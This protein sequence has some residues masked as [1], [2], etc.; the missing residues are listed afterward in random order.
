MSQKSKNFETEIP[1]V[2]REAYLITACGNGDMQI[3]REILKSGSGIMKNLKAGLVVKA[4]RKNNVELLDL[5]LDQGLDNQSE[6][7]AQRYSY[8]INLAISQGNYA[9]TKVLLKPR[10]NP[11]LILMMCCMREYAEASLFHKDFLPLDMF[12][13][14]AKE[15][16]RSL[17]PNLHDGEGKFPLY[18]AIRQGKS[19]IVELLLKHGADPNK[20]IDIANLEKLKSMGC[21]IPYSLQT[22]FPLLWAIQDG[23]IQTVKYLIDNGADPNQISKDHAVIERH[24]PLGKA[25]VMGHVE[26]VKYLLE[27]KAYLFKPPLSYHQWNNLSLEIRGLVHSYINKK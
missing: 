3:V 9:A 11:Q 21:Y 7:I 13:E 22:G 12:R 4:V 17:D 18:E 27:Q 15:T 6:N 5:L 1:F 20:D 8:A 19:Q 26:I 10:Y 24:T 25:A 16:K 2:S 14:I 23:N